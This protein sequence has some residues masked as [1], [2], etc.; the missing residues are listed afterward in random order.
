MPKNEKKSQEVPDILETAKK[1]FALAVEAESE[2]R[3]EALE[4]LRFST[5]EQWPADVKKSRELDRRPCLTINR[6]P[7]SIHQL[8]NDQRQN[9]PSVKVSPVDDK[10]DIE[11]AKILQGI[12]RHIEYASDADTAYDTAFDSA[13]RAGFG[14]VR[15]VTEYC[16]PMSFEQ[17]IRIKRIR[18]RFSAYLD[19][20]YQLPDGSDAQWGFVVE[21][22]S[23]EE[24]KAEYPDSK[25]ADSTDFD[26]LGDRRA[27]WMTEDTFRIAEY[28]YK[29]MKD[30]KIYLL[31]DKS[32]VTDAEIEEHFQGVLP[33]GVTIVDERMTQLPVIKW[34]KMNGLEILEETEWPGRWIPIIPVLGEELDIDGKRIL[35]GIVRDA[36]DP[37]R[38]YNYWASAETETI[39][40]APRAPFI[41]VEG[42]FEGYE[43]EWNTANVRNH[44]FLQYKAKTIGGQP[45]GPP[46]R[47]VY[48]PPVQAITQARGMAA[49]DLKATTGIYDA[50][51]GNRSNENSGVAI[52]RRAT[53][54]Q[55]SNFHFMDNL[56]KSIRHIGRILVDLIPKVYDT[57]RAIRI[58]G[59][60]GNEEIIQINKLFERKGKSVQYNLG[61]GKYDV[62]VN[63]GPSFE[64]KRQEAVQA[65]LDLTRAYPQVAQ[66]AGDLM[67]RNMDW[68]GAQDIADRLKKTLPP[69][70]ADDKDGKQ[71]Q[72]PPEMQAQMQQMNQMIEQL[73][74]QLHHKTHLI[75]TKSL[76]LESR[77][78]IEMQKIQA[79]I[80]IKMAEMGSKESLAL[81][82]H[83]IAEIQQRLELLKMDQPFQQFEEM[84]GTGPMPGGEQPPMQQGQLPM[85]D[86]Q[87]TGG[88]SPGQYIGE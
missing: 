7:N 64:S 53:Q 70:L 88:F 32:V 31:S 9:R 46:Q 50:A 20:S 84:N 41:G 79:Q 66:V 14:F 87:P 42:Q 37:Q 21:D 15:V 5:G 55:T 23:K 54:A 13:V 22:M 29:E 38:M 59:E 16:D 68:P 75:E 35:K 62:T 56:A 73:T 81:L 3:K 74:E 63:T 77:E 34:V 58:L 52:Q 33:E 67:V 36:K 40:L 2:I 6:L 57:E 48:E 60:D 1:R 82:G 51:L 43:S 18:N 8:T 12:I 47:N 80:E 17:D 72:A 76:E 28:F 83:E 71:P 4:D 69:G 61:S 30:T 26:V 86:T 27:D 65:M 25:L 44:A 19:P 24:Y 45:V 10:A 78:R 39:A 11:V 85:D 49:E